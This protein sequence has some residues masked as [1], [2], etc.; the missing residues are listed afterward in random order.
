[1]AGDGATAIS[2]PLPPGFRFC[3]TDGDLV[4]HYLA[5]KAAEAG[6]TSAAV[7]DVDLYGAEPWELL[8][9][10]PPTRD[11]A[12][13]PVTGAEEV[14][15]RCGYFFCTRSFRCPSGLRTNRAT[16]AGYWKSTGKDKAVRHHDGG[17]GDV[18]MR[19]KKTLV[20]YR[21]RAPRGEK[22]SWVMHEY[23]LLHGGGGGALS[24]SSPATAS[25]L[26]GGVR[27]FI[28]L[29]QFYLINSNNS[30][31]RALFVGR[32]DT[33]INSSSGNTNRTQQHLLRDHRNHLLSSPAPAPAV[34]VDGTAHAGCS[35]SGANESMAPSDRFNQMAA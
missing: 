30:K 15:E 26:A 17:D 14:E 16:A 20:F 32:E 10:P 4:A 11:A 23:R 24:S 2:P 9:P 21:E 29:E 19:V 35:F 6:F 33:T 25:V 18:P 34:S 3:P 12:A 7:R 8:P 28:E 31:S 1:M 22:T 13:G 27:N 5:R